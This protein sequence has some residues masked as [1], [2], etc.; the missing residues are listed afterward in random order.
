[1]SDAR[2]PLS[3]PQ[4][5]GNEWSYTKDCLDSGWVAGGPYISR[6]EQSLAELTGSP[7]VIACQSGT[8]ALHVAL[9]VHGVGAGDAVIVPAVT[10]IATVN[11]V[12]YTG[13]CPVFVDCDDHL[14]MDPAGVADYLSRGCDRTDGRL[15]DRVTGLTV[16]AIMPVHVF[17]MPCD[18][19]ALRAIAEVHG[20][21][22]IEDAA[23]S[24]GSSWTD[25]ELA[26][27][28]TGTVGAMGALSFNGNKIATCGGG[29][30]LLTADED[31]AARAR[32]LT[33]QAKVDTVR[34][35]H[36]E[37]GYNYR[38]TN[39]AA[40]MGVAQLEQLAAFIETKRS[41]RDLYIQEL[42]GVPGV[43]VMDAPD[44]TAPNW[45]FYA[46]LIEP[47]E[48]GADWESVMA[49]LVSNGIESRPLW[50]LNNLQRPYLT[51]HTWCDERSRYFH[52]RVLNVP[53]SSGLGEADVVRVC[54]AIRAACRGG[55]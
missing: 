45:W 3:V 28:H 47:S 14:N 1:M 4:I 52:D 21:P 16:R 32:H 27:R 41:N 31:L 6:F 39:V 43:R 36:D 11:A 35:V 9:L 29:G 7:H 30:A 23:E 22:I 50:H 26:G 19:A 25:G 33:T 49:A 10:F 55:V 37:V 40:A 34:F 54:D 5:A 51:A 15:V 12:A 44:G 42:A 38:L 24:L 2:I 53:C 18:M 48:A 13:A 8:A 20:L 46:V 17:G